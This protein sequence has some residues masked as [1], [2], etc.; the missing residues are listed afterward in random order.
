MRTIGPRLPSIRP[1][2]DYESQ[3]NDCGVH[4]FRS[5][6]R[7]NGDGRLLCP[8]CWETGASELSAENA[9]GAA[10]Y[11]AALAR[12]RPID[13][14]LFQDGDVAA[15][16]AV[17]FEPYEVLL[18]LNAE[19]LDAE[20]GASLSE[21]VAG[22]VTLTLTGGTAPTYLA[23]DSALRAASLEINVSTDL[24]SN[25]A[26]FFRPAPFTYWVLFKQVRPS[27]RICSVANNQSAALV[28]G[29]SSAV[30]RNAGAATPAVGSAR[31]YNVGDWGRACAMI[32]D[33]DTTQLRH[34]RSILTGD[35]GP[36][37]LQGFRIGASTPS[38]P[39]AL[40]AVHRLLVLG[41]I[42]SREA[43]WAGDDWV[44]QTF[45]GRVVT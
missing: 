29:D 32:A 39:G 31:W 12:P 42:P 11:A 5:R 45:E 20:D 24:R 43:L 16:P 1:R 26:R 3:C 19:T 13:S 44:Q 27:V 9:A 10:R 8:D 22:D 2:D 4:W 21:V 30:V 14:K 38:T 37:G 18:D 33:D 35:A 6:M 25:D 15:D 17:T 34:G 28:F 23:R 41:G 36:D 7:Y 40:W